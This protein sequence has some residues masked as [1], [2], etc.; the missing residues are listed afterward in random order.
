[1]PM[2]RRTW[3]VDGRGSRLA[4]GRRPLAGAGVPAASGSRSWCRR[5]EGR[6]RRWW[7]PHRW[8]PGR[9]RAALRTAAAAP[10]SAGP[11]PGRA[12]SPPT[13]SIEHKFESG[14]GTLRSPTGPRTAWVGRAGAATQRTLGDSR[15]QQETTNVKV[16]SGFAAID[17]GSEIPGLGFHTAE[18]TWFCQCT[19]PSRSPSTCRPFFAADCGGR[20]LYRYW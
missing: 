14:S 17:V 4:A 1:V 10:R 18:P 3:F 15:G 12:R 6:A 8:W 2:R 9:R 7:P 16:S 20:F 5:R 19:R 13:Q 11:G